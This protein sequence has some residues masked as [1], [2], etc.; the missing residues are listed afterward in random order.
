MYPFQCRHCI[1][2]LA[3][4]WPKKF[5]NLPSAARFCAKR[6]RGFDF[7]TYFLCPFLKNFSSLVQIRIEK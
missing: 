5:R 7:W 1:Y 4:M 6:F 2:G 3:C